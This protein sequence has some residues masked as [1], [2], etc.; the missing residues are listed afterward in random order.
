MASS[1]PSHHLITFLVGRPSL[2]QP[3]TSFENYEYVVRVH[4]ISALDQLR[5]QTLSPAHM[6]ARPLAFNPL[7]P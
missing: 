3:R 7:H 4:L 6:Q 5:L 1:V 2:I